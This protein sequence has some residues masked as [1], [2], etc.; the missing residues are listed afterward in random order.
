MASTVFNQLP[1]SVTALI[2][3]NSH[4]RPPSTPMNAIATANRLLSICV[5]PS[6]YL[7]RRRPNTKNNSHPGRLHIHQA[8]ESSIP[9]RS[10]PLP[11][12]TLYSLYTTSAFPAPAKLAI[13]L[14]LYCFIASS[15]ANPAHILPP[16]CTS[17]YSVYSDAHTPH[18]RMYIYPSTFNRRTLTLPLR[19]SSI[20]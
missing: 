8:S 17:V 12:E 15:P 18:T 16:A 5:N 19:I 2:D 20:D 6:H 3:N 10:L 9:P 7:C 1:R 14:L 11:L 13:L 4:P